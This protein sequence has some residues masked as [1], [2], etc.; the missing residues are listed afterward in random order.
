[1]ENNQ[2]GAKA[3]IAK[4][5]EDALKAIMKILR[6]SSDN[7]YFISKKTGNLASSAYCPKDG[8]FL[9]IPRGTYELDLT[10][11]S[12]RSYKILNENIETQFEFRNRDETMHKEA[13]LSQLDRPYR[14][15]ETD[16]EY[17]EDQDD[18]RRQLSYY[19]EGL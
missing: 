3:C 16:G 15:F 19:P 9:S 4:P 11:A 10:K 17:E 6:T 14:P 13:L 5:N 1:M 2:C 12:A 7:A 8:H 18:I